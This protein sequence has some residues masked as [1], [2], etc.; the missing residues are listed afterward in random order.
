MAQPLTRQNATEWR[1][2]L[3]V[4]A[5]AGAVAWMEATTVVYWRMLLDRLDPYQ[6]LPLPNP[7]G[8][9][10][11]EVYR[12]AST[13]LL[14]LALGLLAG[15]NWRS[16]VSY[17]LIAFGIWDILYY[18][19]LVVLIGWPQSIL[20]WDLL[21]MIPL[22]WWGPVIAPTSIAVMLI[23]GGTLVSQFDEAER[24]IWPSRGA[25]LLTGLGA[26]LALYVFMSDA[27]RVLPQGVA[28]TRDVLPTRFLWPLFVPALCLMA[29]SIVDVGRQVRVK[30]KTNVGRDEA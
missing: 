19:S 14:F 22:P 16:R 2:W 27:I 24:P 29:T 28:A 20:D 10:D 8:L 12:E 25:L 1:R 17:A 18:V 23:V 15:R 30:E 3:I 11:I 4:A 21:F 26:L 13:L 7:D 5:F 9:C 6:P